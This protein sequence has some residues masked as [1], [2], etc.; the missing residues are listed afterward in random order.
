MFVLHYNLVM[1]MVMV[2]IDVDIDDDNDNF[3]SPKLGSAD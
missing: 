1:V 2:V 3:V